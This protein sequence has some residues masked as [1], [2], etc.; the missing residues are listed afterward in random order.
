M[1]LTED[2]FKVLLGIRDRLTSSQM[3]EK[4]GIQMYTNDPRITS[5]AKKYGVF[6][7]PGSIKSNII[8]KADFSKIEVVSR[9]EMPYFEYIN[10][11]ELAEYIDISK[12][13]VDLLVEYFK[14]VSKEDSEKSYR[15]YKTEGGLGSS[16]YIRDLKTNKIS[17]LRTF[18]DGEE[19][20]D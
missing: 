16:L 1:Y 7:C 19:Y 10:Y 13:E 12:R 18:V 4:Y 9:E 11:W 17:R 20:F 14:N 15:L 5:L 3:K 8:E 2:E 6:D